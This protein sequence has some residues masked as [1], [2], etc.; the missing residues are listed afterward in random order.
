MGFGTLFIGY[1]LFLNI[2]YYEYTDVICALV[3]LMG[4]IRLSRYNREFSAASA[5]CGLFSV[6]SVLQFIEAIFTT[7]GM[8]I[9]T[10]LTDALSTIRY[11]V[12]GIL[13]SVILLG[14]AR[15]ARQV[16]HATLENR[17]RVLIPFVAGIYALATLGNLFPSWYSPYIILALILIQLLITVI[18]LIN[19][20]RSYMGICLSGDNSAAPP[21]PEEDSKFGFVNEMRRQKR[22]SDLEYSEAKRKKAQAKSN[23][24]R[25]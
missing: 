23:K 3:M 1:F 25:K 17:A 19:I 8:P 2:S 7:L 21:P 6:M 22:E 16:D 5:I 4:L 10:G 18:V 14:I 12:I 20:Y 13:T 9:L 15:I 11:L 24:K